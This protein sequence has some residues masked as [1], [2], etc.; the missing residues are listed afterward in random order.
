MFNLAVERYEVRGDDGDA[1]STVTEL[2]SLKSSPL[3]QKT[4]QSVPMEEK[5]LE[6]MP[7][8]RENQ[9]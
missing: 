2:S 6:Y 3:S 5:Q 9:E 1:V 7:W 8:L 4:L